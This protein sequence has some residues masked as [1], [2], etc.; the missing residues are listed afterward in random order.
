MME[1]VGGG[2]GDGGVEVGEGGGDG[3]EGGGGGGGRCKTIEKL[4]GHALPKLQGSWQ[5]SY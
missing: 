3:D 1:E 4:E 5:S 2:D